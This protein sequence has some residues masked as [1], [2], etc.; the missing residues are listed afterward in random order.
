MKYRMH[1]MS[2]A[3]GLEQLK[4]FPAEM[5]EIHRAMRYY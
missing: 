1:Q 3:V 5:A 4:K 2:A